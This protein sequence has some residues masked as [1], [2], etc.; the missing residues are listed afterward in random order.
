M[1]VCLSLPA[2]HP[3]PA[4]RCPLSAGIRSNR[5][6]HH[7]SVVDDED[8]A[9]HGCPKAP[10]RREGCNRCLSARTDAEQVLTT[11]RVRCSAGNPAV[12]GPRPLDRWLCVPVF[13]RVCPCSAGAI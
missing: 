7:S 2:C 12:V 1:L 8:R 4:R 11:D 13:R 10:L 6:A 9:M 5:T 3:F